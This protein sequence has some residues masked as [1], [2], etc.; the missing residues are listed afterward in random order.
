MWH[1]QEGMGWW[2]LWGSVLWVLFFVAIAVL[3]SGAI[4]GPKEGRYSQRDPA[5]DILRERYA[6]GEIAQDEFEQKRRELLG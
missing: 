1:M 3:I 2:M 5:M 6:R 4:G